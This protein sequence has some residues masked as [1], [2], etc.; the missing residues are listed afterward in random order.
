MMLKRDVQ[1]TEAARFEDD[2]SYIAKDGRHILRGYDWD[3]RKRELLKRS[4]GR[5]EYI[6]SFSG[7][8]PAR[9][10]AEGAI[11]SHVIPRYPLRDDRLSN[12]KHYCLAHD[13]LT[14]KQNWRRIRSDKAERRV[15]ANNR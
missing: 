14:E 1:A 11:P 3:E 12:L 2:R 6:L 5:C 7:T 9:C 13:R 10:T 4:G 8:G 15:N